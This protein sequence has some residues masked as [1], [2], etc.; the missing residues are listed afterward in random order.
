MKFKVPCTGETERRLLHGKWGDLEVALDSGLEPAT[1]SCFT[2][3]PSWAIWAKGED[4]WD[5]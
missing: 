1:G 5:P 2:P 3:P 4:V